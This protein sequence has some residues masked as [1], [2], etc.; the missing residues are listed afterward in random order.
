MAESGNC[1]FC[2]F[3]LHCPCCTA[4]VCVLL[5][6]FQND[7]QFFVVVVFFVSAPFEI[8]KAYLDKL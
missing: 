5:F 7:L 4:F 6:S 2:E 3:Q 8:F 1:R